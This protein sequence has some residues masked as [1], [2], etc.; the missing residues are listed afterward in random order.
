MLA[1]FVVDEVVEGSVTGAAGREDTQSWTS[2]E[3]LGFVRRFVVFFEC[4]FEV[5]IIVG[6]LGKVD[7]VGFEGFVPLDEGGGRIEGGR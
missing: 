5:I 3:T 6:P 1:L 2:S 4:G 7:G